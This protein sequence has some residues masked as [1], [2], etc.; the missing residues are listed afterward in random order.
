[1]LIPAHRETR[2]DGRDDARHMHGFAGDIGGPAEQ[3]RDQHDEH[4]ILEALGEEDPARGDQRADDHPADRDKGKALDRFAGVE[5]AAERRGDREAEEDEA[6]RVV[7]QAFAF[8]QGFEPARQMDALQHRARR[9]RV[10]RRYDRAER[11]A[12]R[13]G[14]VG[15]DHVDDD[16]DDERREN[17]RADGQ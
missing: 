7:E 12:R 9:H 6:G 1:M 13:P 4:A 10:G 11:E 3:D 5:H 8:E 16:A 14:Q 2:G 17:H 15:K